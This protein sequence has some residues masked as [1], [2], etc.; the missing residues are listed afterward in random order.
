[1]FH[2]HL[3]GGCRKHVNTTNNERKRRVMM[4][5]LRWMQ[6]SLLVLCMIKKFQDYFILFFYKYYVW[7]IYAT[8]HVSGY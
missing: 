7:L 4:V 3:T 6:A 8:V 1:M 5:W 2:F